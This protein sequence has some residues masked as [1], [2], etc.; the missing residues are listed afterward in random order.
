LLPLGEISLQNTTFAAVVSVILPFYNAQ[1][2]LKEA[3]ESVLN[4]SFTRFELILIDNNSTDQSLIIAKHLAKNDSR[5]TISNEMQQ[6][7][8]HAM[9]KGLQLANY[10]LI[11]RIDADDEWFEQ[12]LEK[13]VAF[14]NA[15]PEIDVI[16]TQAEYGGEAEGLKEYVNW[17]NSVCSDE[18]ISN[19]IF[20]ESPIVNPSVMFR[21][22]LVEK[23]G[24]YS[25]GDNIPEDYEMFLRW[26]SK[27]VRMQKLPKKLMRWNDFETRLTRSHKAYSVDAFNQIKCQYLAEYLGDRKQ[28]WIWGAGRKTRNRALLLKE[29]G[30]EINGFI[31]IK[32]QK[33]TVA[34]CIHF[35]QIEIEIHNPIISFVANRGAREKIRAFLMAKGFSEMS[36][37][38]LAS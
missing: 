25:Y 24:L 32:K 7:V 27:G 33:T 3:I 12:K 15:H 20:I 17:S 28:V 21:K 5:I 13:Q 31:D 36:D 11:A 9:N 16:A 38:I 2:T 19:S 4:Q 30:V 26:H 34:E 37:F 14:L 1:A 6:G 22:G 18:Q 8:R 10:N 29:F 23:H 35:E